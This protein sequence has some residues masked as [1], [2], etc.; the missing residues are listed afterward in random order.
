ME[1]HGKTLVRTRQLTH[2]EDIMILIDHTNVLLTINTSLQDQL[3]HVLDATICQCRYGWWIKA[4][5]ARRE[6]FG[7]W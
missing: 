7:A 1:T 4:F 6:G 3:Y 2:I 5:T